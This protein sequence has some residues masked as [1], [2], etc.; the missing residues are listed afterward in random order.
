MKIF[1]LIKKNINYDYILYFATFYYASNGSDIV[2][3]PVIGITAACVKFITG[4][5]YGPKAWLENR[6]FG[7]PTIIIIHYIIMMP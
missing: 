4:T 6:P 5:T 7:S 3:D 2:P 1:I